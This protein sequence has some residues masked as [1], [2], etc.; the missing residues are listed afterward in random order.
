V[1]RLRANGLL[2]SAKETHDARL[3]VGRL[4][5][6]AVFYNNALEGEVATAW[7]GEFEV[8]R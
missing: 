2:I 3:S 1:Y 7:K 5:L 8:G 4:A 6:L